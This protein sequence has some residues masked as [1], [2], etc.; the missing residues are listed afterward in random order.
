[1]KVVWNDIV[2]AEAD[3]DQLIYIEGNWYFPPDSVKSEFLEKSDTPYTCPWK[4]VCQY[5]NLVSGDMKSED[6][7][8]SYPHPKPSAIDTVKKDFSNYVAFWRD[9]KVA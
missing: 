8:W 3:K 1:M 4:G 9:A 5:F 7:A 6:N 2:I